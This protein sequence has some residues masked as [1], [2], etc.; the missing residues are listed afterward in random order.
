MPWVVGSTGEGVPGGRN[1]LLTAQ[2]SHCPR[3]CIMIL[4][5]KQ[6]IVSI[7][8]YLEGVI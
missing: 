7:F 5:L 4:E 8:R 1:K 6:V 2:P 3:T